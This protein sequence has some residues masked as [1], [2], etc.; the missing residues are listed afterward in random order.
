MNTKNILAMA[1]LLQSPERLAARRGVG[2]NMGYYRPRPF[3]DLSGTDCGTSA[4]LAWWTVAEL[5]A[6]H[7]L[8]QLRAFALPKRAAELL[9]LPEEISKQ[10]FGG[11]LSPETLQ[12]VKLE[13]VIKA[14]QT[15]AVGEELGWDFYTRQSYGE[16]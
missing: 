16:E 12:S 13:T 9:G 6:E 10:L 15:V 1:E 2:F 4:C 7:E 3:E 11:N 5:G 14:L 8:K